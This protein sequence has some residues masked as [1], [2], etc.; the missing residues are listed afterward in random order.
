MYGQFLSYVYF[1]PL[2]F[3]FHSC[4]SLSKARIN[5]SHYVLGYFYS[6]HCASECILQF[7]FFLST[8]Y[9]VICITVASNLSLASWSMLPATSLSG[10]PSALRYYE[11]PGEC[12][13][14]RSLVDR[15]DDVPGLRPGEDHR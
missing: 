10:L 9:V 11:H 15:H 8:I 14:A 12:L 5:V 4:S 7:Y 13:R 2:F 6:W 1:I 3:N